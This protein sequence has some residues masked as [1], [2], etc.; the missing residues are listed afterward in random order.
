M[1]G[2]TYK[3]L[4]CVGEKDIYICMNSKM[5]MYFSASAIRSVLHS[6]HMVC[7]QYGILIWSFQRN[8]AHSAAQALESVY[9]SHLL[10]ELRAGEWLFCETHHKANWK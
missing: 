9:M 8:G 7:E 6:L 1:L 2:S 10:Q 3:S 5:Q 4:L